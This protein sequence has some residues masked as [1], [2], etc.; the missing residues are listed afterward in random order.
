MTSAA[1]AEV[2]ETRIAV[3][4]VEIRD[5]TRGSGRPVVVLHHSFG[6]PGWV[7]FYDDLAADFAVHVPDLPGFGASGRPEW[8]RHPRDLA[9]LMGHWVRK[10]DVGPV[11]AVGCGF[12]G[13]VATELATMGPEVF[14]HL[15]LVGSAGLLPADG[16]IFDQFL[17]SHHEYVEAAFRHPESFERVYSD[18][19]SDE[20]LLQWEINREMTTRVAW[21]PYMYN[22][23]MAPLLAEIT[24]PTLL[25]WGEA[26]RIVP[27][28]CADDYRRRLPNARI[29]IVPD[30]GHAVDL[31]RPAALAALVREHASRD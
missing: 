22:R 18:W 28:T 19:R 15:V 10:L 5:Q 29:E 1:T 17:T 6:N 25:V 31:E 16:K 13:W 4:D 8:A 24:A 12:G 23:A 11:V 2:T 9:I 27:R 7:P 30:C 20:V 14:S 3:A 21:K 26:D